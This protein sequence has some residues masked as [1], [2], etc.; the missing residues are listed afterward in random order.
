[1]IDFIQQA[2]NGFVAMSH[3]EY[4]AVALSLAYLLLAM[5]QSLWC[6]PAAFFST[7]IYTVLFYNGALLMDSL[8]NVFYMAMAFYGWYSWH[9]GSNKPHME[10]TAKE[11][12]PIQ[13]LSPLKHGWMIVITLAISLALGYL[14]DNYTHADFAYLDSI[15]TCFSVVATWLIAR[16]VLENWLWWVVIDAVSIYLYIN[17]GYYPTTILFS[18][19]TL[20][21]AWGYLQWRQEVLSGNNSDGNSG[22]ADCQSIPSKS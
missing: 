12:L 6:W 17:K 11:V 18:L 5:K 10:T 22:G 13:T 19:Y 1:M 2:T 9:Q 8:L 20:M 4:V 21:A 14:M 15:T 3:W 7:L 16:K